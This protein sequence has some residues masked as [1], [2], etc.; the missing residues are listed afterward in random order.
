[1][2]LQD[3]Q[4]NVCECYQNSNSLDDRW[5]ALFRVHRIVDD[6]T[7]WPYLPFPYLWDV[8]SCPYLK[9]EKKGFHV[10]IVAI[11]RVSKNSK[12][13]TPAQDLWPWVKKRVEMTAF[14]QRLYYQRWF[15]LVPLKKNA[16]IVRTWGEHLIMNVHVRKQIAW[17]YGSGSRTKLSSVSAL[18]GCGDSTAFSGSAPARTVSG[19]HAGES[20]YTK[21]CE[22]NIGG[23]Q[24]ISKR[25]GQCVYV[26]VMT[27]EER[28][29]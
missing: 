26:C 17:N 29:G 19:L 13:Q 22:G 6:R 1:M 10:M 21:I 4:S 20:R 28:V 18:A 11:N 27:M 2:S 5:K 25:R 7:N 9:K 24:L 15:A 12:M 14:E 8:Q 23:A 16:K 3:Y